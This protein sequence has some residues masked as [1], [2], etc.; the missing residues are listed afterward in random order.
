MEN[1]KEFIKR[2][3]TEFQK[4]K[5]AV[6]SMKDIGRK[7]RFFFVREAWTFM[8]QS[9]LDKKVFV[10]ER[11]RKERI[12]GDIVYQGIDKVGDVEYRIGYFI[13]GE[14]GK[15]KNKWAWGQFCPLIPIG[16]FDRLI[17]KAKKEKTIL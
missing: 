8:P 15:M 17:Y 11:L 16:D 9:N 14:N 2:K 7:G 5:T 3:N 13:V 6:V 4:E 10:V 1:H 12:D